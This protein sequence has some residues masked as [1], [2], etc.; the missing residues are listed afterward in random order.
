[1]IVYQPHF[2]PNK[3]TIIGCG[4]TGSRL[5]PLLAQF[6]KTCA[7]VIDP[8]ISLIDNDIVEEKNLLRQN[9]IR[10]DVGKPKAIVLANRYAK[11]FGVNITP[12]VAKF[13]WD[14]LAGP[15]KGVTDPNVEIYP[16]RSNMQNS[17]IILCV[18]SPK[19][20]RDIVEAYGK[21]NAGAS[22]LPVL[23][24]DSGNENDFGQIAVS[25]FNCITV[26]AEIFDDPMTTALWPKS[27]P[28][29]LEIPFIPLNLAYFRD[30]KE[31]SGG[32][33][34]DLDQTMAINTAMASAIFNV[35]QSFYYAKKIPFHRID[36][37]L[38]HGST[39][40]YIS[41]AWL[42]T[43]G[44]Y[45]LGGTGFR[46]HS[47]ETNFDAFHQEVMAPFLQLQAD[48]AKVAEALVNPTP[49]VEV[50]ATPAFL[51]DEYQEVREAN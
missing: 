16:I 18:D 42:K 19:S 7:W 28:G 30:M 40:Q 20:R 47:F 5:V 50:E 1:M 14:Y 22:I 49:P 35:V 12:Y 45:V 2:V 41:M 48:S 4:G 25:G 29:D 33:C 34:A 24:I 23:L 15:S 11:A 43:L 46:R 26:S 13:D 27:L 44:E 37:S 21:Y 3:I 51:A 9:F 39:P 6:V 10:S 36:I 8:E 17:I 38:L 32:S 31:V